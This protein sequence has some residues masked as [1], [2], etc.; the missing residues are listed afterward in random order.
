ML[1]PSLIWEKA[2]GQARGEEAG[3]LLASGRYVIEWLPN[4]LQL[5]DV[6]WKST[7]NHLPVVSQQQK[8]HQQATGLSVSWEMS[9]S[10][11]KKK[12]LQFKHFLRLLH[13]RPQKLKMDINI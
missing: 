9:I 8:S 6:R 4:G 7:T 2:A 10:I 13:S 5:P 1:S 12:K 11:E 3:R